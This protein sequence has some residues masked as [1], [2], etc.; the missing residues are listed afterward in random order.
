MLLLSFELFLLVDEEAAAYI[1]GLSDLTGKDAQVWETISWTP[2]S[3]SVSFLRMGVS[4]L[5]KKKSQF[6]F[7]ITKVK[8]IQNSELVKY[9]KALKN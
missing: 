5:T 3:F 9:F 6:I 1:W 7:M 4:S 8:H 2:S